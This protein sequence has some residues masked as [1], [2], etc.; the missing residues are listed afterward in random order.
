VLTIH[1]GRGGLSP[2]T[3]SAGGPASS[4]LPLVTSIATWRL[5]LCRNSARKVVRQSIKNRTFLDASRHTYE[6]VGTNRGPCGKPFA[7]SHA[8]FARRVKP[9][10]ERPDKGGG[11]E[12]WWMSRGALSEPSDFE[13][14]ILATQPPETQFPRIMQ[15]DIR[16]RFCKG[17]SIS[18]IRLKPFPIRASCRSRTQTCQLRFPSAATSTRKDLAADSYAPYRTPGAGHA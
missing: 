3:L 11:E 12:N 2:L 17:Q 4:S 15:R 5:C 7:L 10:A 14:R 13:R 18:G 8:F 16:L 1:R 6:F 9:T